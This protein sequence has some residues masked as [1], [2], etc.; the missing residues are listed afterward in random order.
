M[1]DKKSDYHSSYQEAQ[2][3]FLKWKI[4]DPFDSIPPALLNSADIEDY[5]RMT[6]MIYPF[7]KNDLIGATYSVRLKGLCV[8][9][10]EQSNGGSPKEHI[11]CVGKDSKDLPNAMDNS[12]YEIK[13]KLVLE[14]NSITFITLEPVFQVPDYLVLRFNLKI[15][16]VYK[17]LLLGTGPIIDPGFQGRLSIPIHNLT[18]NRY[19]FYENDEIISLEFTKMSPRLTTKKHNNQR[20]GKY[21]QT[22]IPPNR[23][24]TDYL[25]KALG[26]RINDGVISSVIAVTNDIKKTA[27]NAFGVASTTEEKIKRYGMAGLIIAIVSI[28]ITVLGLFFPVFQMIGSF[29]D[30]QKNYE[31]RIHDLENEVSELKVLLEELKTN[32]N[33][34]EIFPESVQSEDLLTDTDKAVSDED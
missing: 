27:R 29:K 12:V 5:I 31:I 1:T 23:Q 19:T 32:D 26:Q 3:A 30:E 10:Q 25:R 20:R 22:K 8:Y 2:R 4:Q 17:G 13:D 34:S 7:H 16:H 6:G 18:S 24:V 11:F 28:I 14:P 33:D 21:I 15:S 9:Y